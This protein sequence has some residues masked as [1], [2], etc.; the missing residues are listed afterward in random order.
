MSGL[1]QPER[2]RMVYK[3]LNNAR[4][5]LYPPLCLLC[6]ST[7]TT[8]IDICYS[9]LDDLPH[10]NHY[11]H[12]CAL[13]LTTD[14][15]DGLICGK[16]LN[17]TPAFDSC[18]TAFSYS[19]P[20]SGLISN[21]KFAGKLHNGRLLANLLINYIEANSLDMPDL[22]LPVPLHSYRLRERGFNQ[23]IELAHPIGSYFNIPVDVDSC[24]RIRATESQA[25]LD[26]KTRRKNIRGAFKLIRNMESDHAVLLDDVVTTGGTVTELALL[27][28]RA[29][30]KRVDVWAIART[31]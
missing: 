9:C 24:K 16:C 29:G 19:Y 1:C 30:V 5:S 20:I 7:K 14:H 15:S 3:W 26:K 6:G 4:F 28:K 2:T 23:A 12:I 18:R 31:P 27:L 22:I 17:L 8:N 21:F 10:N 13:P 11:C 25:N